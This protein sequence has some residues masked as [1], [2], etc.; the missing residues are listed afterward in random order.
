MEVNT[1]LYLGA[2]AGEVMSFQKGTFTT[3]TLLT[4]LLGL[5]IVFV[6]LVTLVAIVK[7][8]GSV[9]KRIDSNKTK[10]PELQPQPSEAPKAAVSDAD[11]G[12]LIAAVS[13]ALAT[14]MG[15]QVSGIRI[16]SMKKV[17]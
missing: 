8:M 13:A 4:F 6:G 17:N 14:V 7:I 15:K 9:M 11:H 3:D 1:M 16:L 2:A 10:L 12:E 5:G